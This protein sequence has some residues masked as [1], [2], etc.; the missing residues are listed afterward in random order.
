MIK[1]DEKRDERNFYHIT[2]F[3]KLPDLE[4]VTHKIKQNAT[5]N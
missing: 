3:F 4:P 2:K 1:L 5:H